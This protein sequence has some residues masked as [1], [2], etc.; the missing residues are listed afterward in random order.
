MKND[1]DASRGKPTE[2]TI[3]KLF[4]LSGNICAFPG[5]DE[6]LITKEGVVVGDICH[7][8]AASTKGPRFNKNS[9]NDTRRSFDNLLL[10]CKKHH[11]IID[12][13]EDNYDVDFLREMKR[14]H[15]SNFDEISLT[16]KLEEA[17]DKQKDYY[18]SM[19][20][21]VY[22]TEKLTISTNE[23]VQD[24][25]KKL[26]S[27]FEMDLS[28][29]IFYLSEEITEKNICRL[30]SDIM[31]DYYPEYLRG[32]YRN[33]EAWVGHRGCSKEN[34]D[35]ITISPEDISKEMQNFIK[36]WN[37]LL[38]KKNTINGT[39]KIKE[40]AKLHFDFLKIHPF[41]DGNGRVSRV[42]LIAQIY[43]LEN[44]YVEN[45]FKN[46]KE[47]YLALQEADKGNFKRLVNIIRVA[48][49]NNI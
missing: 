23:I 11:A 42:I 16:K 36:N 18:S 17:F 27:S 30:H 6:P 31:Q 10:L 12:K 28:D 49:E 21:S 43:L 45:P 8:E 29:F 40:L 9:D 25:Q 1:N 14:H 19:E 2:Q 13:N 37:I 35:M 15:E 47:Y 46:K 20:Q 26:T 3:K 22:D 33:V 32:I 39:Q 44:R 48:F 7:I 5:C 41:H 24:I 38:E 34:C 4:A